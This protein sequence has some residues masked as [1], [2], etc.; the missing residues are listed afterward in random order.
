[1]ALALVPDVAAAQFQGNNLTGTEG[2]SIGSPSSPV[3]LGV[4]D[5]NPSSGVINWGDGTSSTC[6]INPSPPY[7]PCFW[8]TAGEFGGPI[9]GYHTYTEQDAINP[10][11]GLEV[12][13]G[14]TIDWYDDVGA[15][16]A[17]FTGT[18]RI[19]D[20]PLTVTK[21]SSP[22]L[23]GATAPVT[24]A[25]FTD[26]DPGGHLGDYTAN[27]TWGD[28]TATD[29]NATISV[30]PARGSSSRAATRT[31]SRALTRCR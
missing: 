28:G 1:V 13:Y 19:A 7:P 25:R 9:Y 22:S 3:E 10:S 27:I 24:V 21:V 16:V 17:D 14:Y 8:Q 18:A 6:A 2:Q 15:F 11:N 4:T 5:F 26:A 12:P 31:R 23:V 20:A 29:S 30:P